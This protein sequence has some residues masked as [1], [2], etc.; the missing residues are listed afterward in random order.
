VFSVTFL[1]VSSA[2]NVGSQLSGNDRKTKS[3]KGHQLA[4]GEVLVKFSDLASAAAISEAKQDSDIESDQA[5]GGQGTRLF[6]S[7]S[8]TAEALVRQLSGRLDVLYA[9]PNYI[10]HVDETPYDARYSELY[11][12][13][14]INNPGADISAPLVWDVSKGSTNTVIGAVDTGVDYNHPDLAAN[15]WSA[16]TSLA[17]TLLLPNFSS[18]KT[19]FFTFWTSIRGLGLSNVATAGLHVVM[20]YRFRHASYFLEIET[21]S[22]RLNLTANLERDAQK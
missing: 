10:I 11:G 22:G 9:E 20:A 4:A 17:F 5:V 8:K 7:R 3:Y 1:V 21:R 2:K 19:R 16:P 13:H 15:I 18:Q 6:R 12:L 14:N